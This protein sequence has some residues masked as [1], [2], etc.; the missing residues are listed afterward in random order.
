MHFVKWNMKICFSIK[1]NSFLN[2][3][4][5]EQMLEAEGKLSTQEC[6]NALK[7]MKNNKSPGVDGYTAEFYKFFWNDL[8]FYLLNSFNY[9]FKKALCQFHKDKALLHVSQKK[10]NLS[11]I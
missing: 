3:L 1:N 4:S 11:F 10:G 5:E 7:N 9:S 6:L 2:C 8:K